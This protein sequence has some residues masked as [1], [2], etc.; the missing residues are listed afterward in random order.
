MLLGL[1]R[2]MQPFRVAPARHHAAGEFVDDHHLAVAHDVVL[3]ALE[4]LVCAQGL[5]DVM[6]DGDVLDVVE[7]IRLELAGIA[8]PGLHLLH[9]G[10]GEIDG[11]LLLVELVV[12]L[13]E[14]GDIGVDGVVEFRAIVERAGNDQ[15]RARFVDQDGIDLV[16]DGIAMTALDH[17]LQPVFHVVAQIVEA[18]LVI[19]AVRDVAIV[20]LLALGVV[21]AVDD[22]ADREPEE[23]VDLAHPFGVALG[24]VVVDGDDVDT[25][26]GQRIEIDR[27]GC[28]QRL[29]FAGLH[30]SDTAFVQDHAADQLDV[31]MALAEHALAGLADGG[32]SRHQKIVERHAFGELLLEL[33]GTGAQRL[34]GQRFELLL[35]RVDR[36]TRGR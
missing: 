22:D 23:L 25:A 31:E 1:E 5:I 14:P 17:V 8:Q 12:L 16:D 21:E 3:V 26:A 13:V 10:F 18:E 2:L 11:A 30:F 27:K 24:E 32:E 6:H 33:V 15:R 19:G 29:A 4:Q 34:V 9:A 28:D 36:S 7:R 20:L 35:K